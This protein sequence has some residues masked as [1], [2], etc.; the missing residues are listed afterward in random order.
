MN[1]ETINP[2]YTRIK[3]LII[4]VINIFSDSARK[5]LWNRNVSLSK[6]LIPEKNQMEN[7]WFGIIIT[8]QQLTMGILILEWIGKE[9]QVI[10]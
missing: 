5:T 2:I 8:S 3:K 10:N 1:W 7:I 4:L 9:T 6:M